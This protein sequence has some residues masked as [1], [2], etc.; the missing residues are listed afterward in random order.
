MKLLF[1]CTLQSSGNTIEVVW[2]L[3]VGFKKKKSRIALTWFIA[4]ILEMSFAVQAIAAMTT[5]LGLPSNPGERALPVQTLLTNS[6][7][8]EETH[9][10]SKMATLMVKVEWE[11]G[12]S[13]R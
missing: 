3:L 13:I 9:C 11:D 7:H 8:S 4:S 1:M 12:N 6:G 2:A 10:L 5:G